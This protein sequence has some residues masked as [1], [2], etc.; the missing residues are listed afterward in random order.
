MDSAKT[1]RS[2]GKT[3]ARVSP[4]PP[5]CP[6]LS[7]TGLKRAYRTAPTSRKAPSARYAAP[8]P[9]CRSHRP[10]THTATQR[11][12]ERETTSVTCREPATRS[13]IARDDA[14]I[15]IPCPDGTPGCSYRSGLNTKHTCTVDAFGKAQWNSVDTGS[16]YCGRPRLPRD[17]HRLGR[18]GRLRDKQPPSNKVLPDAATPHVRTPQSLRRLAVVVRQLHTT[19]R[20]RTKQTNAGMRRRGLHRRIPAGQL[21]NTK[22]IG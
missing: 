21:R 10:A 2:P 3:N 12:R 19:G 15:Y 4:A 14:T 18:L 22:A 7:R 6:R 9:W 8:E 20:K 1:R 16:Q 17:P 13:T 5:P 11:R